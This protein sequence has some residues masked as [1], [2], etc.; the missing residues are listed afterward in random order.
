MAKQ[1]HLLLLD[2]VERD[3]QASS[4]V[5]RQPATA[6]AKPP[7]IP[8]V[9]FTLRAISTRGMLDDATNAV[10]SRAACICGFAFFV[11]IFIFFV[12]PANEHF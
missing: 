6:L 11:F 5:L 2:Q 12:W 1:P 4:Q 7:E 9:I 3:G 10:T 8:R